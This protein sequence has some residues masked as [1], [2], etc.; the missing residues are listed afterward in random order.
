MSVLKAVTIPLLPSSFSNSLLLS[1]CHSC[2]PDTGKQQAWMFGSENSLPVDICPSVNWKMT[3]WASME[4]IFSLIQLVQSVHRPGTPGQ[5]WILR[6]YCTTSTRIKD[7]TRRRSCV[8][9]AAPA[10]TAKPATATVRLTAPI[11][12]LPRVRKRST[13]WER[14]R[15]PPSFSILV[16]LSQFNLGAILCDIVCNIIIGKQIFETDDAADATLSLCDNNPQCIMFPQDLSKTLL[17]YTVPA[18]QGFFRSISLSR[19]NNLQDTLRLIHLPECSWNYDGWRRVEIG[20]PL[21]VK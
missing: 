10:L 12:V 4:L 2:L 18:V 16:S 8:T 1:N 9:A 13:R 3:S 19:G 11:T 21:V 17:L 7:G 15:Q 14:L 6:L 5:W 20:G